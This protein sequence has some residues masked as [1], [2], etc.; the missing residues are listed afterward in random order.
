MTSEVL[1]AC[2]DWIPTKMWDKITK[3]HDLLKATLESN[4]QLLSK[5]AVSPNAF[6]EHMENCKLVGE[7]FLELLAKAAANIEEAE[8][9]EAKIEED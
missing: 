3:L 9:E 8:I 5:Q 4:K 6:N 1:L 2:K 7:P